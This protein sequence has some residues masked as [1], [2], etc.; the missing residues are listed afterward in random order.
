[1]TTLER[2]P[3]DQRGS[4]LVFIVRDMDSDFIAHT[5]DHFIEATKTCNLRV[6]TD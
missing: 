2:W 5:L 1:V 4:K 3:D 6:A